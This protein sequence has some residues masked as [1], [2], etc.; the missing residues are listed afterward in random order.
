[1]PSRLRRRKRKPW[2]LTLVLLL[3]LIALTY[4]TVRVYLRAPEQTADI[5][6]RSEERRGGT[7]C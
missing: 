3:V 7:E 6:T 5:P 2:G 1:M 4:A